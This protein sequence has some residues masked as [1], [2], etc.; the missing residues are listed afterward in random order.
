M[1]ALMSTSVMRDS[2]TAATTTASAAA[3]A[4]AKSQQQQECQHNNSN[5]INNDNDYNNGTDNDTGNKT[6]KSINEDPNFP[7]KINA[8]WV[9]TPKYSAHAYS[10]GTDSFSTFI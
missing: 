2:T 4:A 3:A 10:Y 5:D 7:I 8:R 1:T 6:T 9:R